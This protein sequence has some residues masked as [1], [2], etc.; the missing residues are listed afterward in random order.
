MDLLI[1]ENIGQRYKIISHIAS[2]GMGAVYEAFDAKLNRPVA[3][4]M[5]PLPDTSNEKAR[6]R[7][8]REAKTVAS[9]EYPGIVP[10][11]DFGKHGNQD[12]FVMQLMTGGTLSKRLKENPPSL[13]EITAIIK[14]LSDALDKAHKSNVIH[15]DL[16]PD[17]I[18]F[19]EEG[20]AH[21]SDFGIAK[22]TDAT[23]NLTGQA[24]VGTF[25][26][27]CPE[28]SQNRKLDHRSDIYSFGII[29]FEM[30]AGRHPF[31]A[32]TPWGWMIAHT[33]EPVPYILDI[34][35]ELPIGC[36][37]IVERAMAKLPEERFTSAK[38][39]ADALEIIT[40]SD[41][42]EQER[43]EIIAAIKRPI[44]AETV[45]NSQSWRRT[46][47]TL[48]KGLPWLLIFGLIG[49]VAYILFQN[50]NGATIQ[51]T[52][53]PATQQLISE[54]SSE[55]TSTV[56]PTPTLTVIEGIIIFILYDQESAIYQEDNGTIRRIPENG[57]LPI[58]AD[59]ENILL[60]SNSGSME[61]LLPDKTR[62]FI[63]PNTSLEISQIEGED[64]SD[65]TLISINQGLVVVI[66]EVSA[67]TVT[68]PRGIEVELNTGIVEVEQSNNLLNLKVKVDCIDGICPISINSEIDTILQ[69]GE[70][71][72]FT[73]SD[74]IADITGARYGLYN[75]IITG[76]FITPTPFPTATPSPTV[77]QTPTNVPISSLIIEIGRSREDRPINA[78]QFGN[79]PVDIFF[80]GGIHSGLA[81]NTVSLAEE[82]ILHFEENLDEIPE[83][84]TL[85]II[86]NLNPDSPLAVGRRD[87][88]YNANGV[89]LNRNWGCDHS[90]N[91]IIG[92]DLEP[93][94]G[95]S[96]PFSELETQALRNYILENNPVATIFWMASAANGTVS[97]GACQEESLVSGSLATIYSNTSNYEYEPDYEG[98]V[99]FVINGDVTNWLDEQGYPA[100]AVLL[101][102]YEDIDFERNLNSIRSVLQS[103]RNGN[104]EQ[105][106]LIRT[107]I[108]NEIV[109]QSNRD[110]DF[111]IYIMNVDGS[112]QRQLTFN[113]QSDRFPPCFSRRVLYR[114]R[115][116]SRR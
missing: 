21:I 12:Y 36:E 103:Y 2:G 69:T 31:Q 37:A 38:E 9:L 71:A 51:E 27:M 41:I 64:N 10:I 58:P 92:G 19:D 1:G 105:P 44:T 90:E 14:R 17:N 46:S 43:T 63:E 7:F 99:G 97:H 87:G 33:N 29:L 4:K 66:N 26:Y 62:L 75:D 8:I 47:Q 35:P 55:P 107:P 67:V 53:I 3:L 98:T 96:A 111:E 56:T 101:R 6:K 95:G 32:N 78:Y 102:N 49:T 24:H 116:E 30:L 85:H 72:S 50:I 57:Q 11:Y 80:V 104:V 110:G 109:F 112:N 88:R 65:K 79:G 68:A 5:L 115:I 40:Q 34:K 106:F 48:L 45:W 77:T 82:M 54:L 60:Q 52:S 13:G 16:K 93:G 113:E 28:Q 108:P 15:R 84:I 20:N 74:E 70:A 83:L 23:S 18:L 100:I 59:G 91:P 76:L 114:L 94:R 42:D 22:I 25:P 89:D 61:L 73:E 81:P 86:P 39:M